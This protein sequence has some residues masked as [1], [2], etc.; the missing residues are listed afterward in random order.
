MFDAFSSGK[1]LKLWYYDD[2]FSKCNWMEEPK[3]TLQELYRLRAQQ[4][5]D[6]YEYLILAYSGGI[7]STNMLETFYYNNIHIDEIL[8]VGAFSQDSYYG[9]DENHNGEIYKNCIPTL[10]M[11]NLKNTKISYVDYTKDFN[12]L[13][14]LTLAK[15]DEAKYHHADVYTS[16]THWW[17]HDLKI[18]YKDIKKK[19]AI[20]FAIDKPNF[21]TDFY[22]HFF[23]FN[24]MSINQYGNSATKEIGTDMI[25]EFFYWTPSMPQI[26][27]KQ[28]HEINTIYIR[29]RD[30][31][32]SDVFFIKT[33]YFNII[34]KMIYQN[35]R[36]PLNFKSPKSPSPIISLRDQY[37]LKKTSSDIFK[38]YNR[39]KNFILQHFPDLEGRNFKNIGSQKYYVHRT[40]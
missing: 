20:V 18:W 25:R 10:S 36:H 32:S 29:L 37:L 7:D 17:W 15:N 21:D 33:N 27:I 8:M 6:T 39:H 23:F 24:S 38:H 11:M 28:V 5:R 34:E 16:P 2:V 30:T 4:L 26:V 14:T 3:E 12:K 9:S 1:P 31:I 13:E 35:I 22:G 40:A 19:K